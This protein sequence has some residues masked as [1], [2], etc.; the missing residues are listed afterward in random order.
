[1]NIRTLIIAA[2]VFIQAGLALLPLLPASGYLFPESPTMREQLNILLTFNGIGLTLM[3]ALLGALL[4]LEK[5]DF[6][7]LPTE[8]ES[9]LRTSAS[10]RI[11]DDEFYS[12]FLR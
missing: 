9:R 7:K 1:M 10:R 6:D 4:A 5:S 2:V 11:R 12:E 8:I 3:T